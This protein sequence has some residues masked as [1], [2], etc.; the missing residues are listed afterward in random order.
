MGLYSLELWLLHLK[1][2]KR[3]LDVLPMLGLLG[4]LF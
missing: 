2:E 1:K 4:F 3:E